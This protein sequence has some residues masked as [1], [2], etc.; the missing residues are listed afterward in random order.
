M[1]SVQP[2]W[3]KA[4][5]SPISCVLWL[6]GCGWCCQERGRGGGECPV[7]S[8]TLFPPVLPGQIRQRLCDRRGG[9]EEE[10]DRANVS[11]PSVPPFPSPSAAQTSQNR[12][13]GPYSSLIQ[14]YKFRQSPRLISSCS[15][16]TARYLA[17]AGRRPQESKTD[18]CDPHRKRGHV[19]NPNNLS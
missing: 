2:L 6:C 13:I 7:A 8:P 3:G 15:G 16:L 10:V 1:P 17:S 12:R 11:V 18:L 4:C 9:E 19:C 5:F 14:T